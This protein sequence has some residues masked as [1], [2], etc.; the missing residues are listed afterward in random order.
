[1]RIRAGMGERMDL[2]QVPPRQDLDQLATPGSGGRET[3][4]VPVDEGVHTG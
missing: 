4:A 3:M 2:C 1:M